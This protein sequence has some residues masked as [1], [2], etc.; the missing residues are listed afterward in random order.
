MRQIRWFLMN[1]AFAVT[2]WLGLFQGHEN[3]Q[4]V[5]LFVCWFLFL[6]SL[7]LLSEQA[8]EKIQKAGKPNAAQSRLVVRRVYRD[9]AGVVRVVDHRHRLHAARAL[10]H[11]RLWKE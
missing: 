7:S 11:G 5:V 9:R 10:A 4:N 1:G 2:V 8:R 6:V 3:A